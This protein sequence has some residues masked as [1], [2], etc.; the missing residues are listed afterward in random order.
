MT[1]PGISSGFN[2]STSKLRSKEVFASMF[3]LS[4]FAGNISR[5]LRPRSHATSGLLRK[6]VLSVIKIKLKVITL[7]SHKAQTTQ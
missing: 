2:F 7:V 3:T 6:C 1:A 4:K 5:A